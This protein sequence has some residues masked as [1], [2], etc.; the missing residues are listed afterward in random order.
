MRWALLASLT[1]WGLVILVLAGCRSPVIEYRALPADMIPARPTVPTIKAEEFR[2]VPG[3]TDLRIGW[4]CTAGS[5]AE[6][7]STSGTSPSLGRCWGWV[8]ECADR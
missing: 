3:S 6:T 5:R 1:F 8:L 4:T 2:P 7:G